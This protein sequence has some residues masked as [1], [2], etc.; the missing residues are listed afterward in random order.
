GDAL[1]R[2]IRRRFPAALIDEFQDTDPIQARIFERLYD[3]PQATLFLIGDPKQAIY[4][5][6]GA[7]VFT[8]MA[9]K[10]RGGDQVHGLDT[11]WRSRPAPGR[12]G[13][14]AFGPPRRAPFVFRDIPFFD[15][16]AAPGARDA[17]SG[18]A[19]GRAPL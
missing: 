19:A 3:D 12:G 9:A 5:F 11:H 10:R 7:D 8:Y 15:S 16:T 18:A 6:R 1:A 2:E 13:K 14:H 4:G 17:L